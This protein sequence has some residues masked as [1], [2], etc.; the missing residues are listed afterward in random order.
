MKL[1]LPTVLCALFLPVTGVRAAQD[2][3]SVPDSA[4][5]QQVTNP[6]TFV[7]D[8]DLVSLIFT[9]RDGDRFLTGL[10]R[11][12][13]EVFED[14]V[15]QQIRDFE[16]QTNLP[17]TVAIVIDV[18]GSI[19]DKLRFEQEAAIEFFYSMIE[20]GRD[21]GMLVTFDSAVEVLQE[22]TDQ[23]EALAEGVRRIRAGGG[24][25][26]YDAIYLAITQGIS[27]QPEGRRVLIVISD[28]ADNSSRVSL[29]ETLEVAQR[30]DVAVYAISTNSESNAS[31]RERERG[32]R[33][34]RMLAEETGG[35]VFFPF[36]L[37]D[38]AVN[39]QD[40]S[41]ELRAQYALTY[42]STNNLRDGSYREIEVRVSPDDY[43]VDVRP[44][45]FAPLDQ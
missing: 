21:R 25:A 2:P 9:V 10:T 13:F 8:V 5:R 4:I 17:L 19:R 16:A 42:V 15:P 20:P 3:Q 26:L 29:T 6:E 30:N 14:G 37:E 11:D 27:Q 43:E 40:I 32:D 35:R 28:G 12:A 38:L 1:A 31:N 33:T 41:D 44:G 23:P 36:R 7:V 18:S 24:T 39:F 45:Y 34:L 22:F